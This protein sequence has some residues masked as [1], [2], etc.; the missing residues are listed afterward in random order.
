MRR[1]VEAVPA[2]KPKAEIPWS[3]HEELV[4]PKKKPG[5]AC[6]VYWDNGKENGNYCSVTGYILGLYTG[7]IGIVG[8]K[9]EARR[10]KVSRVYS[11]PSVDRIWGIWRSYYNVATFHRGSSAYI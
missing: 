5:F 8:N 2:V 1:Y 3:T 10:G 6:R 9:M 7:V 4:A 11:P